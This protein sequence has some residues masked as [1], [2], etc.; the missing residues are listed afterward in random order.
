MDRR[1]SIKAIAAS[2]TAA[3]VGTGITVHASESKPEQ[4]IESLSDRMLRKLAPLE[5]LGL[6]CTVAMEWDLCQAAQIMAV[7]ILDEADQE[8]NMC[9]NCRL[10]TEHEALASRRTSSL[11]TLAKWRADTLAWQ[12][13]DRFGVE[14]N[15][16][17]T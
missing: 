17:P 7:F 8:R 12:I 10:Y 3:A 9:W 5:S 13:L 16:G 1:E 6:K 2:L 14:N 4:I 15:H 11:E